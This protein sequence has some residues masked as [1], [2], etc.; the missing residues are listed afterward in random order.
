MSVGVEHGPRHL[1]DARRAEVHVLSVTMGTTN[2]L[3]LATALVPECRVS[4][5]H[6]PLVYVRAMKVLRVTGGAKRGRVNACL[7]ETLD[8]ADC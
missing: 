5:T 1:T 6:S 4:Q 2:S 8:A 3:R 7:S